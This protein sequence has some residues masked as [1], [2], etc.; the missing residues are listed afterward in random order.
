MIFLRGSSEART[1]GETASLVALGLAGL[2][3]FLN[4][5]ATQPLLPL[6]ERAFGV[7]KAQAAWTV[8]ATAAA[9]S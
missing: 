7:G 1:R 5:Y 3:T 8:S 4:V 2:C 9:G 6:L